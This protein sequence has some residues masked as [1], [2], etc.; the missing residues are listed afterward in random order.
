[1]SIH[2]ISKSILTCYSLKKSTRLEQNCISAAICCQLKC[3]SSFGGGYLFFTCFSRVEKR[4]PPEKHLDFWRS[5]FGHVKNA[6][7]MTADSTRRVFF[8]WNLQQKKWHH[9]TSVMSFFL[10]T[11]INVEVKCQLHFN[12]NSLF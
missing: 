11:F 8:S 1:M 5:F 3:S 10:L 9:R 6:Q 2:G 4:Y 7:K 12:I